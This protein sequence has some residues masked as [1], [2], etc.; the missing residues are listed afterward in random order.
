MLRHA[1]PC[2]PDMHKIH[3]ADVLTSITTYVVVATCRKA[4]QQI[5]ANHACINQQ[6]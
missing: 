6:S 5:Q 4:H 2:V 1:A 3:T